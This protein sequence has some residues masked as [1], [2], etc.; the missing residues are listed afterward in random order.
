LRIQ[1]V[2]DWNDMASFISIDGGVVEDVLRW[3]AHDL[4]GAILVGK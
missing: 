1:E 3:L 4:L 2:L